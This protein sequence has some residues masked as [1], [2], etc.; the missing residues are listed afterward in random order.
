MIEAKVFR[1]L[2]RVYSIFRSE[3]LIVN[4]KETPHKALIRV[5]T[6]VYTAWEFAADTH[7]LKLKRLQNRVLRTTGKSLRC[8]SVRKLHMLFHVPYIYDYIIKL[9]RQQT[10]VIRNHEN[11][12][13]RDI[14]KGNPRQRKYTRFELGGREPYD[15]SSD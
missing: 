5:M 14:R 4:I 1:T 3:R 8:T 10:E 13:V 12:N 11:A 15:R 6:Y 2:I 9:S 7:L